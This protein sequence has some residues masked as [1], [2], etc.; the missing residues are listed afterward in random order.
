MI[1]DLASELSKVDF[2]TVRY[3]SIVDN[4]RFTRSRTGF[5]PALDIAILNLSAKKYPTNIEPSYSDINGI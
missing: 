5:D 1:S 2:V 4:F 3:Q